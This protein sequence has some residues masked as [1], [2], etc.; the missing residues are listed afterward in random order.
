MHKL[1]HQE[2]ARFTLIELLVVIAIIAILAAMLLPALGRAKEMAKSVACLNNQ[3]QISLGLINYAGDYEE[4][5]PSVYLSV[6]GDTTS[7]HEKLAPYIGISDGILG[8][9]PKLR[10][11]G[12]LICPSFQPSA[13]R[14]VSYAY[15]GWIQ[16]GYPWAY[17]LAAP[18][19]PDKTLLLGEINQNIEVCG[20]ATASTWGQLEYRHQGGANYLMADG[21]VETIKGVLAPPP[22]NPC[23]KWW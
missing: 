4:R 22:T 3:R 19:S 10:A 20:P 1:A 17:R 2:E 9:S 8:T 5:F 14:V 18:P 12:V 6:P 16:A 21:H 13:P 15:N 7:W 23:W 11:S